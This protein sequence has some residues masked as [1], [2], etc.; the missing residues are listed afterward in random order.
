MTELLGLETEE[1]TSP[2]NKRRRKKILGHLRG[3]LSR[4]KCTDKELRAMHGLC[5]AILE[6]VKSID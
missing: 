5:S 3:I 1:V 2:S 6:Q 4:S